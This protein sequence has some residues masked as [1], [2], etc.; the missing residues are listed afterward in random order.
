M[1]PAGWAAPAAGASFAVKVTVWPDTGVYT[2]ATK[3][4]G[5]DYSP[6][7]YWLAGVFPERSGKKIDRRHRN[8][9]T[10][11]FISQSELYIR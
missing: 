6:D 7:R 9:R 8:K 2:S 3:A 1:L 11:D 5:K 4:S 10:S